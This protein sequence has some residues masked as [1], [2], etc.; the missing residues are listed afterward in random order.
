[1]RVSAQLRARDATPAGQRWT[2]SV[3]LDETLR[4]LALPFRDF[5]PA[6]HD[7]ELAAGAIESV[8]FVIDGVNTALG[9]SGQV[10]FDNVALGSGAPA[11]VPAA[12]QVRTESRR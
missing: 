4:R 10:W 6:G 1:M 5:L 3:F 11:G 9:Q 7:T 8:L 12:A 2:R